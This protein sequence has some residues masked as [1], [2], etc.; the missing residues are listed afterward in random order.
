[1]DNA[2]Y[3]W[4]TVDFDYPTTVGW[5]TIKSNENFGEFEVLFEIGDNLVETKVS[6]CTVHFEFLGHIMLAM[7]ISQLSCH[8][9]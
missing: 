1:M 9:Q 5:M 7:L 8:I 2:T 3:L 4:I 6:G